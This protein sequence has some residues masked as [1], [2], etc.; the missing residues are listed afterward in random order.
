MKIKALLTNIKRGLLTP[1]PAQYLT[2]VHAEHESLIE[3][4][5]IPLHLTKWAAAHESLCLNNKNSQLQCSVS[6]ILL[7]IML[8]L[9]NSAKAVLKIILCF[10]MLVLILNST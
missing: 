9:K 6:L 4:N 2:R 1:H 8:Y 3:N 10:A 7:K 5:R